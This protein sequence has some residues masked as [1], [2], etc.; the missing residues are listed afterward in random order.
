MRR[1]CYLGRLVR[2]DRAPGVA[3]FHPGPWELRKPQEHP[4]IL[5]S[6]PLQLSCSFRESRAGLR[7]LPAAFLRG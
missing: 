4:A 2:S 7:M 6:H 3:D 1:L 5:A